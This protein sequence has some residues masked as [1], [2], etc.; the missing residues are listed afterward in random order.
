MN[1][2][3]MKNKLEPEEV[4]LLRLVGSKQKQKKINYFKAK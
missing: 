2:I 1:W 3:L 4:I